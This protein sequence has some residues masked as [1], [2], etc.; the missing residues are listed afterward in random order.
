M[1]VGQD[2]ETNTPASAS[3]VTTTSATTTMIHLA[4]DDRR[5]VPLATAFG[6]SVREAVRAI[7]SGGALVGVLVRAIAS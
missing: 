4:A 3:P 7:A 6:G 5:E 1:R 2:R